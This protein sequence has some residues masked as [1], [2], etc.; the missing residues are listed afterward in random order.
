[1]KTKNPGSS[2]KKKKKDI[3]S[4]K[5]ILLIYTQA[6]KSQKDPQL[7]CLL[8]VIKVFFFFGQLLSYHESVFVVELD[9]INVWNSFVSI[10][11]KV[12]L[13]LKRG[14]D[15]LSLNL[16]ILF[17]MKLYFLKF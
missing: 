3:N 7:I 16:F 17:C 12:E 1:M 2:R 10:S 15:Y 5:K 14:I 6:L 11:I 9:R 13:Y 4:W 8:I